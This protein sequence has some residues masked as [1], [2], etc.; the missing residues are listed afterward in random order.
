MSF[1]PMDRGFELVE[2]TSDS[3]L[4]AL[5]SACPS[6]EPAWQEHMAAWGGAPAGDYND[7]SQFA[8][9]LVSLLD[10]G[11][12]SE[13]PAVFRVV[14]K[15]LA[16]DEVGV[17]ELLTVGLIEDLQTIAINKRPNLATRFRE[18]LPAWASSCS[19]R[20]TFAHAVRQARIGATCP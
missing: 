2:D 8:H 5:R 18:W 19:P 12:T 16:E 10:R 7:I 6:F 3:V 1:T 15:C 14:E 17:R 4:P 13:F 11:E 20:M 9:H